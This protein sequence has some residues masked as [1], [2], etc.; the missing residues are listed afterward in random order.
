MIFMKDT[1]GK[2]ERVVVEIL[3]E[4]AMTTKNRLAY[5][6]VAVLNP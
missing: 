3:P 4:W 5:G 1:G 2:V 6:F